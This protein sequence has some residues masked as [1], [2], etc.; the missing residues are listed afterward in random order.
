[1]DS[2]YD[3]NHMGITVHALWIRMVEAPLPSGVGGSNLLFTP[4]T[5][6]IY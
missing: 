3:E 4:S 1:M 2:K 6:A 5:G